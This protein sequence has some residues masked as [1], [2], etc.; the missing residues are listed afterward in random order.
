MPLINLPKYTFINGPPGSG[1]STL[2]EL[3]C[4]NDTS[5]YRESF[6]QPIRDMMYA[7]FYPEEGPI[8]YSLDLRD[9]DAKRSI[10]PHTN[11]ITN[12]MAMISF[13][14]KWMK[15]SFGEDIFGRLALDR[16]KLQ[17]DFY[18][19]FLFDDSGF[20]PEAQVMIAEEPISDFLLIHLHRE[21][22][23]FEGDSRSYIHLP[24]HTI[25][26]TN[27]SSPEAMLAELELLLGN[28]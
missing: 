20:A 11:G 26:L 3:L 27:S 13:S 9:G 15:P 8:S 1:K 25:S 2:A 6:A 22:T 14:E 5:I 21:G 28:L 10:I 4:T 7:V 17:E 19:R 24:I 16:C 12:R 23:S 18:S